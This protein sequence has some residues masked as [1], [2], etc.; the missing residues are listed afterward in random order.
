MFNQKKINYEKVK[1][2][3]KNYSI[4][5]NLGEGKWKEF[6]SDGVYWTLPYE[7]GEVLIN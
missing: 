3:N 5:N 2:I 4:I 1:F 7:L 6:T